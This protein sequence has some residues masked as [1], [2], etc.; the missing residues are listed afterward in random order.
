MEKS[1]RQIAEGM[2]QENNIFCTITHIGAEGTC[3]GHWCFY[4]DVEMDIENAAKWEA[5]FE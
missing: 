4:V 2:F 3:G 1:G 5:A